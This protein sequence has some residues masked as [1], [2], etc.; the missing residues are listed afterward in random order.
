MSGA[1]CPGCGSR[2]CSCSCPNLGVIF[3]DLPQPES[4]VSLAQPVLFEALHQTLLLLSRSQRLILF[5]DDVH[6]CD[7]TS[8][9]A[10]AYLVEHGFFGERG[11][12]VLACRIEEQPAALKR[13][14]SHLSASGALI[15]VSLPPLSAGNVAEMAR[16]ILDCDLPDSLVERIHQDT[17]GN[18]LFLLENI[19][20]L[21]DFPLD[22]LA[23]GEIDPLPLS[24]SMHALVHQRLERLSADAQQVLTV[25]AVI[26]SD[27]RLD[28]L[29]EAAKLDGERLAA[30]LDELEQRHL[31]QPVRSSGVAVR[32]RFIHDRIR[33]IV[34]MELSV[35]RRRVYH[36]RVANALQ[37]RPSSTEST[38][39]VVLAR[40]YEEAG[41]LRTAFTFWLKAGQHARRL[42]SMVEARTAFQRAEQLFE[43][44]GVLVPDE[45][46]FQLYSTWGEFAF[47]I[48]NPAVSE[49]AAQGLLT[50]GFHRESPL[51]I[52]WG[53]LGLAGAADLRD[54]AEQGLVY[55]EQ[56]RTYLAQLNDPVAMMLYHYRHGGFLVIH[57][58]YTAA[59]Q[60]L[61][62]ALELTHETYDTEIIE[63]RSSIRYRLGL[64]YLLN[65][66]PAKAHKHAEAVVEDSRLTFN[67]AGGARGMVGLALAE[68][69]LGRA[70]KSLEYGSVALRMV[71]P[72]KNPRLGGMINTSQAQAECSLGHLDAAWQIAAQALEE[73]QSAGFG[74]IASQLLRV[75]GDI[76]RI[77]GKYESAEELYR[78]GLAE[79]PSTYA[80]M[81][82]L[83]RL[84]LQLA[85]AGRI[86]EG[87]DLLDQ[88]VDFCGRSE[89]HLQL[90]GAL[91]CKACA[92][93]YAGNNREA[94]ALANQVAVQST[95][96]ELPTIRLGM[97]ILI[98]QVALSEG[99]PD[100]ACQKALL[101]M[102][103]A[104][105]LSNPN[106][107][108]NAGWVALNATLQMGQDPHR[109]HAR[110][111]VL[112]D[113]MG[114]NARSPAL[115][116][117]YE[118][119]AARFI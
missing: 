49:H 35:A 33:E 40:H 57:N 87:M 117:A 109:L 99:R 59:I 47:N 118:A 79:S 27:F 3:P 78:K 7:E 106:L 21:Q 18:P 14:A 119:F 103:E 28:V 69:Y 26:G 91:S 37:S 5:L 19:R 62:Q 44:L 94:V 63:A 45:E 43:Q 107:E 98:S 96:R 68:Y 15:E 71:A 97:Y 10:T 39:A 8:L 55:L 83:Y 2:R 36:L 50:A 108:M 17:G 115:R 60:D 84:G 89:L 112:L 22:A 113:E 61:E 90:L 101:A 116:P 85:Y 51:L 42:F 38:S 104:R 23:G 81:D 56:A 75:Q 92:L 67:Q 41:E 64:A 4:S 80:G 1:R 9:N 66:W 77:L 48:A 32:Y 25:A 34:H 31:L 53:Y 58:R 86:P 102:R 46:V 74:R 65:G 54:Q 52:G 110:L 100:E 76:M 95:E 72:M 93:S 111:K 20:A 16:Y 73:G 6:W 12:L 70:A 11:A 105:E 24:S 29:E 82:N 114:N 30:A 13:L 88:A